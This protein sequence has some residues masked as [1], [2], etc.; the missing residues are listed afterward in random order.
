MLDLNNVDAYFCKSILRSSFMIDVNSGNSALPG[1]DPTPS[2]QGLQVDKHI[3]Y[4]NILGD[5]L[6]KVKSINY[7][8]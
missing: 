2:H 5:L 1:V 4:Y 6:L 3:K 7:R 8:L